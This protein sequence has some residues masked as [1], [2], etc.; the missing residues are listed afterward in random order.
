MVAD[1]STWHQVLLKYTFPSRPRS[2]WFPMKMP[3]R[4]GH[5]WLEGAGHAFRSVRTVKPGQ[6]RVSEKYRLDSS[7][8]ASGG[9]I[10]ILKDSERP[11]R[12]PRHHV[13]CVWKYFALRPW[14]QPAGFWASCSV[15]PSP[16]K[17]L[18]S[19]LACPAS[20]AWRQ[21][22]AVQTQQNSAWRVGDSASIAMLSCNR[23]A[24]AI[25]HCNPTRFDGARALSNTLRPLRLLES[26]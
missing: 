1:R 3:A 6:V 4:V 5:A 23:S 9:W 25:Y 12:L 24:I 2:Y 20:G 7:L 21:T 22:V 11:L 26:R 19:P 17:I 15:Y 13:S 16:S 18:A 10:S 8:A 14:C